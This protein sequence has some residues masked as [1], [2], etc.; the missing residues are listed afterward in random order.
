MTELAHA[1][2]AQY[3]FA[4]TVPPTVESMEIL[5]RPV[6]IFIQLKSTMNLYKKLYT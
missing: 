3:N 6:A 5:T 2:I 1:V 4:D